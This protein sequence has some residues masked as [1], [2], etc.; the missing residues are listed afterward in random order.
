[1][2]TREEAH[3]FLDIIRKVSD[4]YKVRGFMERVRKYQSL[5]ACLELIRDGIQLSAIPAWYKAA[6]Q[7]GFR[8]AIVFTARNRGA[9]MWLLE[10]LY[11][12]QE[13]GRTHDMV[14]FEVLWYVAGGG[15][16][17]TAEEMFRMPEGPPGE[18]DVV[19]APWMLLGFLSGW[20]TLQHYLATGEKSEYLIQSLMTLKVEEMRIAP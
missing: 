13:R 16:L 11:E 20:E 7:A 12:D 4:D 6:F 1:M 10:Q 18:D 17:P 8:N 5:D 9:G 14:L 19:T 3:E 15:R 2:A